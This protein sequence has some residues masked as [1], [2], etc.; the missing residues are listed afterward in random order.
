M[1][2]RPG[3]LC[4][5]LLDEKGPV[6][7]GSYYGNTNDD[8]VEKLH[9]SGLLI[10]R[11]QKLKTDVDDFVKN[12]KK[13]TNGCMS[14][15]STYD[16]P[17]VVKVSIGFGGIGIFQGG[18]AF[19]WK[20]EYLIAVVDS[21]VSSVFNYSLFEYIE[22]VATHRKIEMTDPR[23]DPIGRAFKSYLFRRRSNKSQK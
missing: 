18:L 16:S 2:R 15:E 3:F 4:Q 1:T 23:T 17:G 22:D 21:W 19:R 9:P 5:H 13:G 7:D 10:F 8:P 11:R 12:I 14:E 6:N 20:T